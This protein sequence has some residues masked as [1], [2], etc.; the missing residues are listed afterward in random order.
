MGQVAFIT[1]SSRGIGRGIAL[2]LADKGFAIAL[3]GR[4]DSDA[5]RETETMIRAKGVPVIAVPGDVSDTTRH[6]ALLAR[7]EDELGPLTTLVCNAGVP[8]LQRIDVMEATVESFDHCIANNT[9]GPYFLIQAFARRLLARERPRDLHHSVVVV[10]SI[11]AVAASTNRGDYCISKIGVSMAAKVFAL[12]L[13]E[14]GIQV[15]EIRPGVIATDMSAPALPD[16]ER[17]I[18]NEGLTLER[19]VGQPLDIGAAAAVIA[20]G[21]LPYAVGPVLVVDGGLSLTR[22]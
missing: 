19:R 6:D 22:L 14:E 15:G 16:Y 11:N 18:F 9:R 1:G 2:T 13:A 7:V 5:L 20:T 17:R 8:A 21:G 12:R 3:N 10:S 4:A